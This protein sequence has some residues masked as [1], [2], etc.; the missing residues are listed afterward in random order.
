MQ[1]SFVLINPR[2]MSHCHVM[3]AEMYI[4]TIIIIGIS[5]T[6]PVVMIVM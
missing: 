3:I 5:L 4:L 1:K 2:I 6:L